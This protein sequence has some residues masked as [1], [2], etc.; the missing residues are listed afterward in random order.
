MSGAPPPMRRKKPSMA[1]G[2]GYQ[3]VKAKQLN[4][5]HTHTISDHSSRYTIAPSFASESMYHSELNSFDDYTSSHNRLNRE[6]LH[7][8]SLNDDDMNDPLLEELPETAIGEGVDIRGELQFERLLRVDGTFEGKLSSNGSVVVGRKGC[9][10]A[11]VV[12]MES[13]IIDSGKVFGDVQVD[14]LILR[15]S[16]FLNGNFSCKSLSASSHCTITG[17]A[18]VHSLSPE[19]ID[20]YGDIIMLEQGVSANQ[21]YAEKAARAKAAAALKMSHIEKVKPM[22]VDPILD[23][24]PPSANSNTALDG[25]VVGGINQDVATADIS[26]NSEAAVPAVYSSGIGTPLP[27]PRVGDSASENPSNDE[28]TQQNIDSETGQ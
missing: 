16:A 7:A 9:L 19:I 6:T 28:D 23:I 17:R 3:A 24:Q 11:D 5:E 18:N 21:Y 20:I 4:T 2:G 27:S 22:P 12:G 25:E 1:G 13:L 26:P 14:R 15:G 10:I 8:S